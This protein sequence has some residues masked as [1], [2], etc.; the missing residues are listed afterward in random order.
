MYACRMAKNSV[1]VAQNIIPVMHIYSKNNLLCKFWLIICKK[2][3]KI[4]I[5]TKN[6][7]SMTL[8]DHIIEL[9]FNPR[10]F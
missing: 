2:C 3:G 4:N 5:L 8:P 9:R 6:G 1:N 7:A 10:R